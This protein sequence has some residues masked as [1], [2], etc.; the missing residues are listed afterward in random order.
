MAA[1][2]RSL[3]PTCGTAVEKALRR[4]DEMTIVVHHPNTD[5]D[6]DPA[7]RIDN[8]T[9]YIRFEDGTPDDLEFGD[10]VRVRI[11]DI[12]EHNVFAVALER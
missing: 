2:D 3:C 10:T 12:T 8:R 1:T 6:R 4:G 9:T 11:A 7:G 5:A